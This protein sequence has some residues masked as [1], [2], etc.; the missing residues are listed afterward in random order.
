[1]NDL[2]RHVVIA[3]A[4]GS[5]TVAGQRLTGPVDCAD[6]LATLIE[7][8]QR[9]GLLQPIGASAGDGAGQPGRLWLIGAA[10]EQLA[11]PIADPGDLREPLGAALAPLVAQ[12]WE[13]SADRPSSV[14]VARGR[15]SARRVVQILAEPHPWLAGEG[16]AADVTE[17]ARRLCRWYAELGVLP[18]ATAAGS[19]AVLADHIM[20]TRR[21]GAV[22]NTAGELPTPAVLETRIQPPWCA[23]APQVEAAFER[24]DDLAAL[25]QLCPELASAGMV[26]LGYGRPAVLD[27]AAATSAAAEKRPF[28]LWRTTLPA[29]NTLDLPAMLP[30]PH[31]LMRAEEPVADVWLTTEDL[32]GLTKNV[33]DGGAGVSVAAV[34][35][36]EA[37]VWPEQARVL[38]AWAKRL[39]AARD[40]LATDSPLCERLEVAAA[41]YVKALGDPSTWDGGDWGHHYQPAWSAAIAAHIRARGRRKAMRIGR[42]YRTWPLYARDATMIYAPGY[43]ETTR[44]AIDLS[45]T[46]TSRLGRLVSTARTAVSDETVLAVL[47]AESSQAVAEALT[48]AL[49]IAAPGPVVAVEEAPARS[50]APAEE[51]HSA[52]T[53]S[54]RAAKPP[55]SQPDRGQGSSATK[56]GTDA[57]APPGGPV[58]AVLHT[59]GLW[60]SEGT[61]CELSEPITH[62]GQVAALALEHNLGYRLTDTYIEPGQIWITEEA[63]DTFGIDVDAIDEYDGA[64][65]L[66]TITKGIDFVTQAVAA[67]WRV[68]TDEDGVAR[69]GAWTRVYRGEEDNVG[70]RVAVI[71]GLGSK[72]DMPILFHGDKQ[73]E[74]EPAT[75]AQIARR[76]QLFADALRFPWKVSAWTTASDLMLQTRPKTY[77]WKQWKDVVFAPSSTESPYG[78]IDT[79]RDYDWSR[80]PTRAERTCR[81]VHA[82]DRGASYPAAIAGLELPIG[83]PTHHREGAA[84]DKKRPGYWLINVPDQE[85]WRLPYVLNPGG[86][87]FHEPKWACTP[88][89]ERAIALGYLSEEPEILEAMIWETHARV[90]NGWYQRFA[91]ASKSLDVS[92]DLDAQTARAQTKI[93]RTRAIGMMGSEN[94]AKE[95]TGYSPE[96]RFHIIAKAN[97]NIAYVCNEIGRRSDRWPVAIRTDTVLYV[98]D[99]ADPIAAWP[100]DPTKLGRGFGQYKH[101]GSALLDTH[102]EFL[103]GG[104]YEGK[105]ALIEPDDWPEI[106]EKTKG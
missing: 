91:A 27:S 5:F 99:V 69:M 75:P 23:P 61:C 33:R 40:N 63:C 26:L 100:G 86:V 28:A 84:F 44:A 83:E 78:L 43:D 98:S 30:L 31:P 96:R 8:A 50:A 92:D 54:R 97:A 48:G 38:E 3:A 105:S 95:S 29:A 72:N 70:V 46:D 62:I 74:D 106:L 49:A 102:A 90:L 10:C 42:E 47:M 18:A 37:I 2:Q 9:R 52:A 93:A 20:G 65:S 24:S 77:S 53:A 82:Y 80:Q 17:L 25:T 87:K 67:G 57:A 34:G 81:Y 35:V 51:Q 59:D 6:K 39:R 79:T 71:A 12:G 64:R 104:S 14:T 7:W 73:S 58:G 11:G 68:P 1:M 89:V 88:T 103:T 101:E 22:V 13:L 45:E 21:R 66:Q 32:D 19:A 16:A 55:A 94:Y 56:K 85:D 36:E 15:G 4:S 76:I 60:L 41:E